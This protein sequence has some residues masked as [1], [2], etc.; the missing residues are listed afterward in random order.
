MQ[1][2]AAGE[3]RRKIIG[4]YDQACDH[5]KENRSFGQSVY[6]GGALLSTSHSVGGTAGDLRLFFKLFVNL[7][8]QYL[9]VGIL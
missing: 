2:L 6:F 4:K 9:F 7:S 8:E 5:S 3:R 1:R